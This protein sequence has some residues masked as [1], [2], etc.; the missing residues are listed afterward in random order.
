[1]GRAVLFP[2]IRV[3]TFHLA[4]KMLGCSLL[5]MCGVCGVYMPILCQDTFLVGL[6]RQGEQTLLPQT[7]WRSLTVRNTDI[8]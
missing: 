4:A 6:G 3:G 2:D 1:M 7:P 5:C 8:S